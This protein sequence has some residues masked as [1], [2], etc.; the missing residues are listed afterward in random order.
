[1]LPT[2]S[3]LI[4][5]IL[6][7]ELNQI[8]FVCVQAIRFCIS[9]F[10]IHTQTLPSSL[11]CQLKKKKSNGCCLMRDVKTLLGAR[12]ALSVPFLHTLQAV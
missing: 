11:H 7:R 9:Y 4:L 12:L 1:M 3:A 2:S 8:W 6:S 10:S 5:R